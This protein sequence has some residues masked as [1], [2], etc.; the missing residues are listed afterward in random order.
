VS[1]GTAPADQSPANVLDVRDLTVAYGQAHA[2]RGLSLT[3]PRGEIVALLGPNGAGKSST[4][5]ALSG[6]IRPKGGE[7][8]LDGFPITG[9]P[10]HVVVRR[11]LVHVPEGRAILATLSV[12]ANLRLGAHWR[13]NDP[14][15]P[16][17]LDDMCRRFPILGERRRAAA[18]TLSAGDQQLLALARG[19]M[20]RPRLLL[21]DEPSLGLAPP[22]VRQLFA[23]ITELRQTGISVLLAEQNAWQ[24]LAIAQHAYVMERG[25]LVLA[26]TAAQVAADARMQAVLL[27]GRASRAK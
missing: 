15:I 17:E 25:R 2:V 16:N 6:L 21:L 12:E 5:A 8:L 13:G 1:A 20:A 18:G 14:A 4:L 3:V 10:A 11:G 7:V 22:L 23:L 19:L 27:G 26:G 24:A 9:A